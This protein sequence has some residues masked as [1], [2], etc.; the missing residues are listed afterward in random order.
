MTKLLFSINPP[1]D[2]AQWGMH[3]LLRTTRLFYDLSK[4]YD[5]VERGMLFYI[6]NS[7]IENQY[8]FV[9]Q[10]WINEIEFAGA[11]RLDPKSKDPLTATQDTAE[12][13]FVIPQAD[14]SSPMKVTGL[15][16]R[17]DRAAAYV[18]PAEH[19]S[20]NIHR[21]LGGRPLICLADSGLAES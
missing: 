1:T 12:N 3:P 20:H 21:Q 17:Y 5:C 7:N 19:H 18:V 15:K 2:L 9:M 11:V 8:E 4:P 16:L 13:I 10:H 14:E 6:I